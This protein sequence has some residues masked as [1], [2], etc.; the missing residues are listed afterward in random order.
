VRADTNLSGREDITVVGEAANI[1]ETI[2][3]TAEL[4]P[5]LIILD[6]HMAEKNGMTPT[7][8]KGSLNGA[9]VLAITFGTDDQTEELLHSVGAV[10]LLDKMDLAQELIPTILE[11]AEVRSSQTVS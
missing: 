3:K 9:K 6:V 7:E 1:R 10:K 8:V 2:Q 11:L 5:D 4:H